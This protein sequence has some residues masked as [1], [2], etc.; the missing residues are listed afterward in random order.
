[1]LT[2]MIEDSFLE[3]YLTALAHQK[4]QNCSE[5]VQKLLLQMLVK[6]K[7]TPEDDT[8]ALPQEAPPPDNRSNRMTSHADLIHNLLV[9]YRINPLDLRYAEEGLEQYRKEM[10]NEIANAVAIRISGNI[11]S[12][13]G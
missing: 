12:G 2:I 4:E 10:K 13:K 5:I 9:H 7:E 6:E 1:M 3:G 8:E 11:Y